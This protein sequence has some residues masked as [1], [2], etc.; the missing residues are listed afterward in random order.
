M[1]MYA[2]QINSD[3]SNKLGSFNNLHIHDNCIKSIVSEHSPGHH[4]AGL[5]GTVWQKKKG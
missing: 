2:T 4:T 5:E 3:I 1:T